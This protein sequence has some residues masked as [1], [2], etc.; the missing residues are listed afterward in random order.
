MSEAKP[1]PNT[2]DYTSIMENYD[3][4]QYLIEVDPINAKCKYWNK[5]E[6]MEY[7]INGNLVRKPCNSIHCPKHG[8]IKRWQWSEKVKAVINKFQYAY[9][10]ALPIGAILAPKPYIDLWQSFYNRAKYRHL[11]DNAEYI[12]I[13]EIQHERLHL[14]GTIVSNTAIDTQ[15]LRQLWVMT[16]AKHLE[17]DIGIETVYITP[18]EDET[19]WSIYSLKSGSWQHNIQVP[20][21]KIYH[22]L[23]QHSIGFKI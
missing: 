10:C 2:G 18:M 13:K 9:C 23:I 1:T 15:A 21:Q 7:Y 16:I 22:R 17:V 5:D 6:H 20:K 3:W 12:F 11:M 4:K 8:H 14:H 19:A